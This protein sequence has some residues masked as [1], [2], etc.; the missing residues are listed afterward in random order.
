MT[1]YLHPAKGE[2]VGKG[3]HPT[4]ITGRWGVGG[5]CLCTAQGVSTDLHL[6]DIP[7]TTTTTTESET[8]SRGVPIRNMYTGSHL[9][10]EEQIPD[11]L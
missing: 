7:P 6:S 8:C 2:G 4:C 1:P 3:S 10:G 9:G 11:T 5:F